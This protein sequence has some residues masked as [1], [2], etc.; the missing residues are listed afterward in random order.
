MLK[1]RIKMEVL[2]YIMLHILVQSKLSVVFLNNITQMLK[3]KKIKERLYYTMLQSV[4]RSK[5][6]NILLKNATQMLMIKANM[7]LLLHY[8]MRY[9]KVMSKLLNISLNKVTQILKRK[10]IMDGQHYTWLQNPIL[11]LFTCM[12]QQAVQILQ[13]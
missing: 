2:H 7:V 8:T 13:S 6:S 4:V 9:I 10:P 12:I 3:Q 11:A 1:R 5:L